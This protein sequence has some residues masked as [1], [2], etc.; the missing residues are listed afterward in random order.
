MKRLLAVLIIVADPVAAQIG[1]QASLRHF[2][3]WNAGIGWFG[4]YPMCTATTA[5]NLQGQA[6]L[7]QIARM[8][9]EETRV[10]AINLV[11]EGQR[12]AGPR[13]VSLVVQNQQF[14]LQGR[15]TATNPA[16]LVVY[17]Q[18]QA[19]SRLIGEAV[20][21]VSR[22]REPIVVA[23]S[24]AGSVPPARFSVAGLRPALE[25]MVACAEREGMVTR[26]P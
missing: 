6:Q 22:A 4:G 17:A 2:G 16:G 11:F 18:S 24:P 8:K 9:I 14:A 12:F 5:S 7:F 19:E 25:E 23:L 13:T 10:L 26:R 1:P 21:A 3:D 20:L 15:P